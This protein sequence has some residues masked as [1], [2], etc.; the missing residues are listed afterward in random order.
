MRVMIVLSA[1]LMMGVASAASAAVIVFS[2]VADATIYGDAEANAN[3]KGAGIFAGNNANQIS[4]TR[5][6][7]LRF[8]LSALPAGSVVSAVTLR[9]YCDQENTQKDPLPVTLH[10]VTTAW[11]EGPTAGSGGGVGATTGDVTWQLASVP[12]V[13]WTMAG[14][15][16]ITED[17]A[18]TLVGAERRSYSW[19][20]SGLVADVQAWAAGSAGNFGWVIRSDE[21]DVR[22]AKR[23]VSRE[24]ALAEQRPMLAV[25]YALVPE[26]GTLGLAALAGL[27]LGRRR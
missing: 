5:R 26:P 12:G 20:G 9:L 24:G 21:T 11:T 16:F 6:G 2:P 13:A 17:S 27:G 23:F 8:D 14:G 4:A 1:V 22:T 19:S 7:L 10:R 3:G 18:T 25:E 15:D